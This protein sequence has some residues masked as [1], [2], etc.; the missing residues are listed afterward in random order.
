MTMEASWHQ[1]GT[2]GSNILNKPISEFQR[3][4]PFRDTDDRDNDFA[5]D[6]DD[7]GGD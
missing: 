6:A 7:D 2:C 4:L 1:R 3:W 5:V